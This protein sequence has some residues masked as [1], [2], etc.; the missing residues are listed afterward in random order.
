MA[1]SNLLKPAKVRAGLAGGRAQWVTRRTLGIDI[2]HHGSFLR[3]N[4]NAH[5]SPYSSTDFFLLFRGPA[6]PSHCALASGRKVFP[7]H[8]EVN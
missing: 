3:T 1:S 7:G 8:G 2:S 6:I 4:T 5:K